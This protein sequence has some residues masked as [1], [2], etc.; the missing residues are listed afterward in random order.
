MS[1]NVVGRTMTKGILVV[2][3][4]RRLVVFGAGLGLRIVV[5]TVVLVNLVMPAKV[6]HN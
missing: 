1:A 2:H 5:V 3:R 6:G 4:V